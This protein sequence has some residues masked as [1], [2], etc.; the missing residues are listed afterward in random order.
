MPVV[1]EA[2]FGDSVRG[3]HF[4]EV[5]I[6]PQQILE[7][8]PVLGDGQAACRSVFLRIAGH[9]RIHGPRNPLN[10]CLALFGRGLGLVL[11]RHVS[12]VDFLQNIFPEGEVPVLRCAAELVDANAG[13]HFVRVVTTET[14]F[15]EER[16]HDCLKCFFVCGTVVRSRIGRFRRFLAVC[17]PASDEHAHRQENDRSAISEA[18]NRILTCHD[19]AIPAWQV[20]KA[21]RHT[22]GRIWCAL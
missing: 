15:L 7:R 17:F 12:V 10:E 9:C 13:L 1:G 16:L 3:E 8:V 20:S 2:I 6:Q 11:R 21:V 19:D 5:L 4:R 18:R 14:V 22:G